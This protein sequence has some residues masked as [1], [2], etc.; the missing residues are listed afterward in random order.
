M[1]KKILISLL[2]IIPGPVLAED[3]AGL[4]PQGGYDTP[5]CAQQAF[6]NA[7]VADAG[8]VSEDSPEYEI[9]QWV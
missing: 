1:L 4:P 7:L 2:F 6:A 9:Q 3:N 5:T 8:A